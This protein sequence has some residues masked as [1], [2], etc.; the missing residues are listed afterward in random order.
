MSQATDFLSKE[1]QEEVV[2]AIKEAELN[3][4]GE[5]RLHI[6]NQC[7]EDDPFDRALE[8]FQELEMQNT[9]LQNGVLMYLAIDDHHFVIAGDKGINDVVEKDFWESTKD[10]VISNFKEGKFKEGLVQGILEAGEQLKRH[11]PYQSDDEN[12]LSDDISY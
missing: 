12:E 6:E 4:S 10:H 3:T 7:P 5:I 1:D 2:Q 11:F 8:V 9:E